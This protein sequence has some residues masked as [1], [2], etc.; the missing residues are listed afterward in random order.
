AFLGEEHYADGQE[1]QRDD[2]LDAAGRDYVADARRLHAQ[3][4]YAHTIYGHARH[5]PAGRL[6]LQYWFFYYYNDKAFLGIGLHEGDWEMMQLR[7][8][9]QSKPNVLTYSQHR[10]GARASWADVQRAPTPDGPAPVVYPA[11]GSH[12]CYFRPG[13]P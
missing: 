2:Y 9:R 13:V 5:D 7:L 6:W 8:D 11:R 1:V 3:P 12:A 4:G 10:E